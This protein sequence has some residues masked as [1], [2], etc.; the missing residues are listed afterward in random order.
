MHIDDE[1]HVTTI[2][3]ADS[4]LT[5]QLGQELTAFNTRATGVDDQRGL[6]VQMRDSEGSLVA[7]LTGW[8]WGTCAGIN[9]V[10][11]RDDQRRNGFGG[12]LL[13][14]AE[15]E[16]H[17]RGCTQILVSSFTFQAPDF[18]KRHGYVE[19]ARSE[20]I[21]TEGSADVHMAKPLHDVDGS[22]SEASPARLRNSQS[23]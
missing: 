14:A 15:A 8:T 7:G 12:E 23:R 20:G 19:F 22:T 16:A 17:Q 18:Y 1:A 2:G 5:E 10:W 11:V 21:P 4:E 6:S 9:L 13:E 3:E